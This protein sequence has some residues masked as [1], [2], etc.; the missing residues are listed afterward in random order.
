MAILI[1][2]VAIKSAIYCFRMT[3]PYFPSSITVH[4]DI[5]ICILRDTL[6]L[7][8]LHTVDHKTKYADFLAYKH[9][10]KSLGGFHEDSENG[11]IMASV[12][13]LSASRPSHCRLLSSKMATYVHK[14]VYIFQFIQ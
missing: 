6:I 4:I 13:G 8:T 9:F 12:A 7:N 11:S 5:A 14:K 1:G 10:V 3:K 2:Y